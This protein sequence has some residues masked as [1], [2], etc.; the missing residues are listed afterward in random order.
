MRWLKPFLS[1]LLFT[2]SVLVVR[3][4]ST[5]RVKNN[6]GWSKKNSRDIGEKRHN[7]AN[8]R[9]PKVQ[10]FKSANGFVFAANADRSELG[11]DKR[12][13]YLSPVTVEPEE[14]E[15][16]KNQI[17][18]PSKINASERQKRETLHSDILNRQ[19]SK[20]E[21]DIYEFLN[22]RKQVKE[23]IVS[24]RIARRN[25]YT[26]NATAP[27]CRGGKSCLARCTGNITEWRSDETLSCYCDTACYEIFNDCCSDYTKYCGEQK[28]SNISIKKFKWT[29]ETLGH[30]RTSEN[31]TFGEGIWMVSRCADDWPHDRT[32]K[33]C[34][35]PPE[36][37]QKRFKF[38]RYIP[39]TSGNVTFQNYFCAKCNRMIGKFEYFSV[40]VK[41][42]LFCLKKEVK[43]KIRK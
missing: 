7:E 39:L 13:L 29:C 9:T 25:V 21:V 43:G 20:N 32:R 41:L 35:N 38:E 2:V 26:R 36:F 10:A 6:D 30:F 17:P 11:K 22:Q 42:K 15:G 1:I 31:C 33:N 8:K 28:P 40:K 5:N 34:E 23:K 19:L 3:S 12:R 24:S 37:L 4:S 16:T 14:P 18:E 27:V